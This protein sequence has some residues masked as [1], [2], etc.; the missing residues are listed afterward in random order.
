MGNN[1]PESQCLSL[2]VQDTAVWAKESSASCKQGSL[3][4]GG[5]QGRQSPPSSRA[6]PPV[7]D[8]KRDQPGVEQHSGVWSL[9]LSSGLEPASV[10]P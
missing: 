4:R 1:E 9:A 3:Q 8:A 7:A 10:I 5:Q 6:E 2:Q